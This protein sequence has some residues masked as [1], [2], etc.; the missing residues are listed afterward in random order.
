MTLNLIYKFSLL[1]NNYYSYTHGISDLFGFP[2]NIRQVI[3]SAEQ[4]VR[5]FDQPHATVSVRIVHT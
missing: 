4:M 2:E 1:S 5:S 3:K